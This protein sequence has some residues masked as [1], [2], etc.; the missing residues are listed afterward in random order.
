MKRLVFALIVC[1]SLAASVAQATQ[2]SRLGIITA[3]KQY[4]KWPALKAWIQAADLED[5]WTVCSYLS[6][7][8]PQFPMVTNAVV[9]A[10]IATAEEV[11][12]IL[13]AS[14]DTSIPDKTMNAMYERDMKTASGRTHWHGSNTTYIDTN[15]CVRVWRYEDGYTYTEKWTPPKSEMERRIEKAKGLVKAAEQSARGKPKKVAD[16]IM[17]RA[18]QEADEMTNAVKT[19]TVDVK[20]GEVL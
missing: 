10:G 20:T 16:I 4:G 7:D 14:V 3:A 17:Q 15:E 11:E 1:V 19:V 8:Y 2:Y 5:E 6:D 18:Y 12:A 9:S 13:A